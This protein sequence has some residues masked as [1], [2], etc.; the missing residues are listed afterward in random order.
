MQTPE[1]VSLRLLFLVF[2]TV[3]IPSTL[4]AGPALTFATTTGGSGTDTITGVGR[5]A[6]GNIYYAGWTDSTTFSTAT[7]AYP[8]GGSVDAFVM[9]VNGSSKKLVYLTYLGGSGDDRALG[10]VVDGD[11]YVYVC[12]STSSSNFP[13]AAASQATLTGSTN[14]FLTKLD[15]TGQRILF[16]TYFGGSGHTA[17][18]AIALDNSG[19][20]YMAGQTD[21]TSLPTVA[22]FQAASGGAL[23]AFVAKFN[24]TGLIQYAS[25]LG[26][27]GNDAAQGIAVDSSGNAYVTGSTTSSNFPLRNPL[28]NK[29]NGFEDAFVAKVNAAGSATVYSTYLGGSGQPEQA[30]AITVDSQGDAFVAGTTSSADF[31]MLNAYQATFNGWNSDAFVAELTPDGSRLVFST[32]LGGGDLDVAT[33]IRLDSAGNVYVVG[34]TAS[35]DFPAVQSVQAL[36]GGLYDAFLAKLNPSG[37]SLLFSTVLGGRQNDIAYSLAG[38]NEVIV[39]GATSSSDRFT[40]A[41]GLEALQFGVQISPAAPFG[42]IDTPVDQATGI[43][44]AIGVTGWAL[45][46]DQVPTVAV[47]REALAGEPPGSLVLMGNATS[48][49]GSRPDVAAAFP[50]FEFN[51]RAGWGYAILSNQLPPP[52]GSGPIGNGTYRFHVIATNLQGQAIDIGARTVTVDNKDS[53]QPFGTI[54]T[55]AQG[56]T[57]SGTAY[58]NFGW[59]VTPQPATIPLDGS[60]IWVYI[61]SRRVGHPVFNN[62]RADIATLFPGL[63]NSRGAV[64]YFYINTT[65]LANGIHTIAWTVADNAGH[66]VGIGSRYFTVQN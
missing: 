15:L 14:A 7:S 62:Y 33:G 40:G 46:D 13:I 32:Y 59:A 51:T 45:C 61:D 24:S 65:Q 49:N 36:E 44:G 26:G 48:V 4:A 6:A 5:D 1:E 9:K 35:A 54:D 34:Y 25:Y 60:T 11:G 66:A 3:G 53:T 63:N 42:T 10:I 17:A 43:N 39:G 20:V 21:S 52:S 19:N 50:T 58:V 38:A 31:P 47:W 18:N 16:S 41:S 55:P 23:D 56:Q 64:G 27:F 57:I 30:N 8:R 12:G 29:L 28:Q 37:N 2:L 22:P